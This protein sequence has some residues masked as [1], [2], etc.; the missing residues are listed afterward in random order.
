MQVEHGVQGGFLG[1]SVQ[2]AG[3]HEAGLDDVRVVA[4]DTRSERRRVIRQLLEH[5]FKPGEIAEA[6]SRAAAIALV[7]RC[8]PDLIVLEIQIPLQDGLDLITELG[9]MS[10]R[11]RIV[12]C[13]FHRDAATIGD[14]LDRGADAYVTKPASSAQLRTALGPLAAERAIRHRPPNERPVSPSPSGPS[15]THGTAT[16]ATGPSLG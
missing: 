14:A 1:G 10:P 4:V 13:S 8:R 16:P 11:P 15:A 2:V 7:E 3:A 5:S 9:L 12:V 6:D